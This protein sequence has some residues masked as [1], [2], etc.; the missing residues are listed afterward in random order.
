MAGLNPPIHR[1]D[2][3]PPHGGVSNGNP[4]V[5][6]GWASEAL[7]LTVDPDE[8]FVEGSDQRK[9]VAICRRCP[10]MYPCGA[11]ALDYNVEFGVWG[12]MTARQRRAILKKH[13]EVTS[14]AAFLEKLT[15][16]QA[17]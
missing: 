11:E 15:T 14:W 4:R 1:A 7:C 13:P 8:L 16:R 10:V 9:A 12:G 3:G 2:I 6:S 17:S 5:R